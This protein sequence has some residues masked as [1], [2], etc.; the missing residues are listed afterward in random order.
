MLFLAGCG[1]GG[2]PTSI[3]RATT[4]V[5]DFVITSDSPLRSELVLDDVGLVVA[6][7]FAADSRLFF[8]EKEGGIY[9][10]NVN[11]PEPA[12]KKQLLNLEVAEGTENGLLGLA[13]APDFDESHHF[14]VY[15]NVPNSDKEPIKSR[16]VRFTER[17][18]QAGE[19]T[20]IVDD[21]PAS[22]E[23]RYHFGGGLTFGPDGKL[24]LIFGDRNMT[25]AARD[26]AQL[27][28][29]I[30]RYNPDGTIPTDNPFPDSPVYAYGIRNGFGLAF[31]PQSGLLYESENGASCDDELNL[32]LPGA[33]YG[34]GVH[35]FDACPY[36]DDTGQK[37]LH[38]WSQ[39]VAP[40]DLMFYTSDL[41]PEFK[42]DLLV[43]VHN[44]S[45]IVHIRLTGNGR[46]IRELKTIEIPGQYELCRVTLTQGPDG[47]IYTATA[48]RI[49]RIGR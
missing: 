44:E 42:G 39:V 23:Q 13:L 38:Q 34:W 45:T 24:Y 7:E 10:M 12:V 33:D 28:G 1:I 3:Q 31:D 9:T 37:P 4:V 30:L 29:S 47:W 32:I 40:A 11:N 21:L 14:Y 41:M 36:P 18:N 17:D 5:D 20:V 2:E 43:C 46:S 26:P 49:H 15:Y 35:A 6:M 48:D 27:P 16:I 25:E 19:E 22:P 8:A